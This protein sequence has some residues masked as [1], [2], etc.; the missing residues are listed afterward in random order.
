MVLAIPNLKIMFI[1]VV[2]DPLS[3]ITLLIRQ[4]H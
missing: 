3:I 4:C 2:V 1:V